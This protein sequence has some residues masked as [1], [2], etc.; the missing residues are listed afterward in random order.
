MRVFFLTHSLETP[1]TRTR[2]HDLMPWFDKEGI[3][4]EAEP[5]AEGFLARSRQFRRLGDYD[6]VL[7]QK[8]LL[9]RFWIR[10][11]R[12]HAKKL[13]YDFDDA[14]YLGRKGGRTAESPTRRGRFAWTLQCSDAVCVPNEHLASQ[15][16]S[17]VGSDRVRVLPNCLDLSRWPAKR[18]GDPPERITVGWIGSPGNHPYLQPMREGLVRLC[19]AF[20]Q[21]R[22]KIVSERPCPMDGVPLEFKPFRVQ[23]EIDD[24]LSFDIAVACYPEDDWTRA[25]SPGKVLNSMAAGLAVVASDVTCVRQYIRDGENGLLVRGDGEWEPRLRQ[26]VQDWEL[27]GRLGA[28]ARRT[29]Q[30]RHDVRKVAAD[31]VALFRSFELRG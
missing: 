26:P 11:L 18:F 7:L 9:P 12:K 23:D 30:E 19:R 17:H 5:M 2:I 24:L 25:K 15:A 29:V 14:V 1:S 3:R 20:P 6:L 10:R 4:C 22:F 31:Y 16:A 27:A 28:A 8:R 21:V 13:I